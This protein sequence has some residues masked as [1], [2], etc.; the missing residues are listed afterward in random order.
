MFESLIK[1]V[2]LVVIINRIITV[3]HYYRKIILVSKT[4]LINYHKYLTTSIL[5]FETK[6]IFRKTTSHYGEQMGAAFLIP[7]LFT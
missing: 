3:A 6:W 2:V 7:K 5:V 4:K 1:K